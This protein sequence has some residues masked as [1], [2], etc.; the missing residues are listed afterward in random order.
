[1]ADNDVDRASKFDE[2]EITTALLTLAHHAGNSERAAAQLQQQGLQISSR[3]LRGWREGKH[4]ERY[5]QL[6]ETHGREIETALIPE[7]RSNAIEGAR[8]ALLAIQKAAEEIEAGNVRDLAS[9]ARNLQVASA[10]AMDKLYLATDRPNAPREQ[11]SVEEILRSLEHLVGLKGYD[12]SSTAEELPAPELNTGP[13]DPE[14][15]EAHHNGH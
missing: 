13:E 5:R 3:T 1:M 15:P 10:T 9:A 6:H 2:E 12:T 14:Q 4:A 8:V 11:R 7:L